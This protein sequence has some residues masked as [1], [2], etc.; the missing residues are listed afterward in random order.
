MSVELVLENAIEVQRAFKEYPEIMSR[1]IRD[2]LKRAGKRFEKIA[3][4]KALSG[5]PGIMLPKSGK[6]K[7]KA[8][9][10]QILSRVGKLRQGSDFDFILVGKGVR[11]LRWHREAGKQIPIEASLQDA[12]KGLGP[13]IDST[14][15]RAWKIASDKNLS[16]FF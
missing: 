8:Q 11:F 12:I 10:R 3:K 5:G 6:N 9:K 13:R 1:L 16:G 15:S 7:K 14:A 4:L 2:E